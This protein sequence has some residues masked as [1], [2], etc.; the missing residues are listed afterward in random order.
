MVR[1]HLRAAA[2]RD[3]EGAVGYYR[4]EAGSDTALAFID[5]YEAA[6]R[7]LCRH[8]RMGSLRFAFELEI[9]DL[10]SWSLDRFPHL[11]FYVFDDE[12]IDI[13]RVLHARRDI[14]TFLAGPGR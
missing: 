3:I 12:S 8:P 9:P 4:Y 7:S 10:R 2:Q 11:I 6:V 13:W 14:P 5:S 1:A